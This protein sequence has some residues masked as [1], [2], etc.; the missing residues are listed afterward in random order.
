MMTMKQINA[1]LMSA[2][3]N[4]LHMTE[5]QNYNDRLDGVLRL[6]M[7][8]HFKRTRVDMKLSLIDENL[9][10]NKKINTNQKTKEQQLAA[11]VT[12]HVLY[13]KL[14]QALHMDDLEK[15]LRH[16]GVIDVPPKVTER[17]KM[18]QELE[19]QRLIEKLH[20]PERD[21]QKIG[22]KQFEVLS[23]A[24]FSCDA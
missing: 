18:L 10:D 2:T 9:T 5:D 7:H 19:I 1:A 23:D 8:G 20:M 12:G 14:T 24:E 6:L 15:E 3:T 16:R 22:K 21:A 11:A 13:G 17:K 4:S